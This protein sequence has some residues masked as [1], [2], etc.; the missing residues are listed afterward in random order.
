MTTVPDEIINSDL[1][2]EALGIA[3]RLMTDPTWLETYIEFD[4]AQPALRD[5]IGFLS[6]WGFVLAEATL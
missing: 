5:A 1:S 6:G 3:V 4:G 2:A